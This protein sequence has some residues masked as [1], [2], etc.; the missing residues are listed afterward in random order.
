MLLYSARSPRTIYP[1]HQPIRGMA[2]SG[3]A[4]AR[5]AHRPVLIERSSASQP[6]FPTG[7]SFVW[8]VPVPPSVML[9]PR[10]PDLN[11]TPTGRRPTARC[12]ALPGHARPSGTPG[13]AGPA[14]STPYPGGGRHPYRAA[15]LQDRVRWCPRPPPGEAGW[16]CPRVPYTLCTFA[17]GVRIARP[18]HQQV[19]RVPAS[20]TAAV[21]AGSVGEGALCAGG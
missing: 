6:A 17:P 18:F 5:A 10:C 11:G 15:A 4:S 1:D 13:A 19:Y 20:R 7:P 16:T 3:S 21:V 9:C 12:R 8:S 2:C 14:R